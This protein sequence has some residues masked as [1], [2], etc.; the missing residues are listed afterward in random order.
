MTAGS[1]SQAGGPQ[2]SDHQASNLQAL[3]GLIARHCTPTAVLG[4]AQLTLEKLEAG[5]ETHTMQILGGLSIA[6]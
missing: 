3:L 6:A 4:G 2:Q 1:Q 5:E